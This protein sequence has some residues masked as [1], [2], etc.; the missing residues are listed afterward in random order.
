MNWLEKYHLRRLCEKYEIDFDSEIDLTLTYD[1]NKQH[2]LNLAHQLGRYVNEDDM[3]EEADAWADRNI[4]RLVEDVKEI[5]R[6]ERRVLKQAKYDVGT[7]ILQDEEWLTH[8]YRD[9]YFG[10]LAR[11]IDEKGY[12]ADQ[13]RKCVKFAQLREE[14]ARAYIEDSST[15]WEYIR[16]FVLRE[17]AFLPPFAEFQWQGCPAVTTRLSQIAQINSL[18]RDKNCVFYKLCRRIS[19]ETE[20]LRQLATVSRGS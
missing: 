17:I 9:N 19:K 4:D 18:C 8:R 2:I 6:S 12:S 1:E 16:R 5:I 14:T 3:L 10:R 13:L 7:R 11:N 15:G 20:S